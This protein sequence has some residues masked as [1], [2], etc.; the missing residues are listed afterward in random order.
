MRKITKE[1]YIG[2]NL[3]A[4][5]IEILEETIETDNDDRIFEL[6]KH[7]HEQYAINNNSNSDILISLISALLISFTGY[8]YVLY[9]YCIISYFTML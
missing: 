8:G 7:L 4:S 2:D 5:P 9:Q 6:E 3:D 1:K